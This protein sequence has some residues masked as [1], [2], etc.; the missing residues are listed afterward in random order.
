M[1]TRGKLKHALYS[2]I[3]STY[4]WGGTTYSKMAVADG[5]TAPDG[6]GNDTLQLAS[7]EGSSSGTDSTATTSFIIPSVIDAVSIISGVLESTFKVYA[8]TV[9]SNIISGD[10][11]EITEIERAVRGVD[12]TGASRDLIPT[13]TIWSGSIIRGGSAS[14]GTTTAQFLFLEDAPKIKIEASERI[15]V[16]YTITYSYNMSFSSNY[17]RC[18]INLAEASDES[19]ITIPFVM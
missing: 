8:S 16:D 15:V 17:A 1:A 4:T 13:A 12:S 18:G 14:Q 19:T 3:R 6:L 7:H 11:M 10:F 9:G 2:M 5:T